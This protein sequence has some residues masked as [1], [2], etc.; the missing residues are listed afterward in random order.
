MLV[1]IGGA[2]FTSIDHQFDDRVL[3]RPD[4]AGHGSDRA[5]LT[6]QVENAG[7]V[8]GG[9]LFHTGYYA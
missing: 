1:V 7:A 2:R 3:A 4:H 9:K 5:T 8:G 6:Q